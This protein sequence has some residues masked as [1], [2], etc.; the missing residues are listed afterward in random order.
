[1]GHECGSRPDEKPGKGKR[2]V[3]GEVGEK[4]IRRR[5]KAQAR[6]LT[7]RT[8]EDAEKN[9]AEFSPEISKGEGEGVVGK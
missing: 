3:N 1:M 2:K 9:I 5:E 6:T 7:A 8:I 4:D